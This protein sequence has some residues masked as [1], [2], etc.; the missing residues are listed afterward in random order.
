MSTLIHGLGLLLLLSGCIE[1]QRAQGDSSSTDSESPETTQPDSVDPGGDTTP[2]QPCT[3]QGATRCVGLEATQICDQGTWQTVACG[4]DRICVDFGGA[5]CL[6]ASGED[7]CYTALY[8][9]AGC[10]FEDDAE[11]RESCS[12]NCVIESSP[13]AQEELGA[14][15]G[16]I[17]ES[18]NNV[19]DDK[20]GCIATSCSSQLGHCFFDGKGDNSCLTLGRCIDNCAGSDLGCRD[21][22]GS[23]ATERAQAEY[24][25]L[26][27]CVVF[28]C[29][30]N[31]DQDCETAAMAAAGACARFAAQCLTPNVI[32]NE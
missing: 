30:G 9:F 12:V 1:A 25:S 16:C 32:G 28:A 11:D 27:L 6:A 7:D 10:Q 15:L 22:C 13:K 3:A 4:S 8:C 21:G 23:K 2:G 17:G 26:E 14:V 5:Q 18:C 29:F 19:V 31:S 24:A 20:L